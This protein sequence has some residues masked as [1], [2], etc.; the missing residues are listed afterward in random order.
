MIHKVKV[1]TD[2]F[3]NIWEDGLNGIAITDCARISIGNIVLLRE[4]DGEKYSGRVIQAHVK[5]VFNSIE[6]DGSQFVF[7]IEKD[8]RVNYKKDSDEK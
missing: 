2:F 3:K 6:R 8:R 7:F 4:F 5:S 1:E